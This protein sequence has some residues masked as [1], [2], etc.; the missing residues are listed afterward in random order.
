MAY[1]TH[2]P[3]CTSMHGLQGRNQIRRTYS[4][5]L[6]ATAHHIQSFSCRRQPKKHCAMACAAQRRVLRPIAGAHNPRVGLTDVVRAR[7]Q[8]PAATRAPMRARCV[9]EIGPAGAAQTGRN[10]RAALLVAAVA[11][12]ADGGFSALVDPSKRYRVSIV[13]CWSPVE[14]GG[15]INGHAESD[16][17]P[18]RRGRG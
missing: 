17:P 18:G 15:L 5:R 7:Q 14:T 1:I 11:G 6:G 2:H 3:E 4:K 10:Y 16:Q 8:V 13:K 9:L 12:L